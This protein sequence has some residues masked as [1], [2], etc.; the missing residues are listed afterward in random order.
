MA[1]KP[2]Y[3]ELAQRVQELE[4]KDL[5]HDRKGNRFFSSILESLPH[6]FYLIDAFDYRITLANSAAQPGPSSKGSTCYAL[7]HNRERPCD[8][9]E[10]PCPVEQLKRTK[11]PVTTEHIHYDKDGNPR[12]IEVS[13]YPVLDVQGNVSQ[14]IKYDI[15]ITE[16][17]RLEKALKESEKQYRILVETM[18]QGFS[19]IDENQVRIFANQRLCEMLGYEREDIVDAPATK[20]LDKANKKLF[21]EQ[22]SKRSRGESGAYEITFTRK[23]GHKVPAIVSPRP[24]FDVLSGHRYYEPEAD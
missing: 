21:E 1:N 18:N 11:Q 7:F 22:F 24:V 8:L 20:V 19:M 10:F 16:R 14:I 4:K 6:P 9:V 17:K 15:D 5:E 2:T 23:D 13:A 3:E 12:N